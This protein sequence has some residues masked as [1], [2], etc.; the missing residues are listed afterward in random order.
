[1]GIVSSTPA[2]RT[3]VGD[4]TRRRYHTQGGRQQE[5]GMTWEE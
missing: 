3:G 5:Q 2:R 4:V 1:M